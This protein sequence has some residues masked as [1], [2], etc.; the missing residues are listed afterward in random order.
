M[1]TAGRPVDRGDHAAIV[2]RPERSGDEP[3][4]RDVTA[5]AFATM[6]FSEG[7]EQNLIGALRA[8]GALTLS[9]VAEREGCVVGHVAFSPAYTGGSQGEWFAL[10]PVAVEPVLQ[11]RGI[12]S[13]LIRHGLGLLAE[14]GAAGCILVGDPRYYAR[15]GFLP[16]PSLAPDGQPAEYFMV[17]PLAA[18][19]P[20]TTID[21]HPLFRSSH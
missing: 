20:A 5:R 11:A 17:L 13:R 15:F 7:D 14:Q 8:A 1:D 2:V 9:L 12:G 21:F 4:I 18:Q 19:R 6:P 10:G 3:A 16:A